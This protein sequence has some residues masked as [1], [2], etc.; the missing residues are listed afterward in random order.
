MPATGT[1]FA[2]P[3][4]QQFTSE[5]PDSAGQASFA[6]VL[7]C[8]ALPCQGLVKT[9]QGNIRKSKAMQQHSWLA[10]VARTMWTGQSHLM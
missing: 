5:D 2:G 6:A 1:T 9:E 4:L 7:P 3:Q 10:M 8:L